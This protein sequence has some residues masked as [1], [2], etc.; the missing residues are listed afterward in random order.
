MGKNKTIKQKKRTAVT[1]KE[2]QDHGTTSNAGKEPLA[3]Y[4]LANMPTSQV[5]IPTEIWMDHPCTR[6][7]PAQTY[8]TASFIQSYTIPVTCSDVDR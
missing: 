2:R 3:A 6:A 1:A 7:T 8:L 5:T 4:P